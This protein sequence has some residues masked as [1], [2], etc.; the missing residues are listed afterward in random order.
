MHK[1]SSFQNRAK[2]LNTY[3]K[4]TR[5]LAHRLLQCPSNFDLYGPGGA[6]DLVGINDSQVDNLVE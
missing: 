2:L 4:A 1:I 6:P 3:W 5:V